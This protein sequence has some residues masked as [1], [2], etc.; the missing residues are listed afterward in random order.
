[1][2]ANNAVEQKRIALVASSPAISVITGWPV[3]F[4]WSEL[5]HPYWEFTSAGYKVD[6]YSPKGGPIEGDGFSDPEHESGYSCDD[7]LSLGFKH[8]KKHAELLAQTIPLSEL[9]VDNYDA[10]FLAGGQGPMFTFYNNEALQGIFLEFYETGKIAAAICHATCILLRAKKQ[11][12]QL[13][14]QH[15]TWTGFSNAEE[16]YID[17]NVGQKLQPFWIESEAKKNADTNFI[18]GPRFTPFVVRDGNLITG[19][20][21]QS[22]SDAAKQV[23]AALGS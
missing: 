23:I 5:T 1:M 17:N 2:N 22:G 8:S 10:L 18:H 12:G 15:K 16:N 14:V 21:Q 4:W 13:L 11:D 6:I 3:G 19:Q 9:K 7:I 20:Q